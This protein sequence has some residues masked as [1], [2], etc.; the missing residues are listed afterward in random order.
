TAEI[1]LNTSSTIKAMAY[2]ADQ[3]RS[4]DSPVASATFTVTGNVAAPVFTASNSNPTPDTIYIT[5]ITTD[6]PEASIRYTTDGTNPSETNGVLYTGGNITIA[7]PTT[8][9]A[10]AYKTDW[11]T[12]SITTV[13]YKKKPATPS[14]SIPGGLYNNEIMVGITSSTPDVTIYYTTNG[15]E[16][17]TASTIYSDPVTINQTL[18]SPDNP[19]KAKA[20]KNGGGDGWVASDTQVASYIMQVGIPMFNVTGGLYRNSQNVEINTVTPDTEIRYGYQGVSTL[21]CDTEI[22]PSWHLEIYDKDTPLVL[23]TTCTLMA[24]ACKGGWSPSLIAQTYIRI[25]AAAPI[26]SPVS[27]TYGFPQEIT[28]ETTT[29]TSDGSSMANIFYTTDGSEPTVLSKHYTGPFS[30]IK[31][32]IVKARTFKSSNFDSEVS[33]EVY[34]R[35]D[36]PEHELLV[37]SPEGNIQNAINSAPVPS[38]ILI[39]E[40]IYIQTVSMKE[41]VSLK[42]ESTEDVIIAGNNS[43]GVGINFPA[44]V[45][46]LTFIEN[47]TVIGGGNP[48]E[49]KGIYIS[50]GAHPTIRNCII[51]GGDGQDESYGIYNN[52]TFPKILNNTISGGTGLQSIAVFNQNSSG[53]LIK[54]NSIYGGNSAESFGIYSVN[55]PALI[56]SNLVESGDATSSTAIFNENSNNVRIFGNDIRGCSDNMV[57]ELSYGIY[58][59]SN[60]VVYVAN[61]IIYGGSSST[62]SYGIYNKSKDLAVSNNTISGGS[63]PLSVAIY[64]YR[65]TTSSDSL[66]VFIKNNILY[67][68]NNIA[69]TFC[70]Y[71]LNTKSYFTL[72]K[73]NNFFKCQTLLLKEG[74]SYIININTVNSFDGMSSNLDQN[75]FF[76]LDLRPD[77]PLLYNG[78]NLFKDHYFPVNRSINDSAAIDIKGIERPSLFTSLWWIGAYEM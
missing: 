54:E 64:N 50:I 43:N 5:N 34:Y 46:A 23:D 25:K 63:A 28:I 74:T 55:S 21:K 53:P 70:L 13:V 20:F 71:E 58:M 1:N 10:I 33:T 52:G 41:G 76:D 45:S 77:Q 62:S 61:N 11:T 36:I 39:P 37:L 8:V 47:I 12:S 35:N 7:Q 4:S 22:D 65:P 75:P 51:D 3:E 14:F 57:C 66:E 26:I 40:G 48:S 17:T 44:S 30:I 29:R 2:V 68:E 73:N 78:L 9:K 31:P 15:S 60:S 6:T 16:P 18:Q 24:I 59:N 32:T 49:T 19:L 69:G 72:V 42:G 67:T 38:I 56:I 27:G